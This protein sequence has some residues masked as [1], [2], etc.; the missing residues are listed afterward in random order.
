MLIPAMAAISSRRNPGVRRGPPPGG[1]PT[2]PGCSRARRAL[3]NLP[4][5]LDSVALL[6]HFSVPARRGRL[7]G[8]DTAR[9]T[10]AFIPGAT[11]RTV[12]VLAERDFRAG[13]KSR[14]RSNADANWGTEG[15][16]LLT[17]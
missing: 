10:G 2:S 15:D 12:F 1:S 17:E 14:R 8:R 7:G 6:T 5:S 9:N 11:A 4:S 13:G 16:S 3:R